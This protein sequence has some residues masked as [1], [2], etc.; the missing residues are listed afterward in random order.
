MSLDSFEFKNFIK[1]K[2]KKVLKTLA[3]THLT[4][5]YNV[6]AII[7]NQ[8][9]TATHC[10]VFNENLLYF[11]Y[12]RPAYRIGKEKTNTCQKAFHPICFVFDFDKI[13]KIERVF[14]FD[15]GGFNFY[16]KF[17]H[18]KSKLEDY[19][20]ENELVNINDLINFFYSSEMSYFDDNPKAINTKPFEWAFEVESYY[21]MISNKA[22]TTDDERNSTIEIQ[23]REEMALRDLK[24]IIFPKQEETTMRKQL[25]LLNINCKLETYHLSGITNPNDYFS[26]IKEI[27]RNL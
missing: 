14:P 17:L 25:R 26:S 3:L 10:K 6:R 27:V 23:T 22:I 2:N 8:K 13:K 24:A 5:F 15:S 21:G 9:L 4:E 7:A 12:G 11:F 18:P 16:K 19:Q 20:L 1:K